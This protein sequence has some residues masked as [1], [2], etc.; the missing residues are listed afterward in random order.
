[1]D[2]F[3]SGSNTIEECYLLQKQIYAMIETPKFPIRKWCSN[4]LTILENIGIVHTDPLFTLAIDADNV[5]KLLGLSWKPAADHFTFYV[6]A[7]LGRSRVIK[8]ML[9]SDLN[10]VFDAMGFLVPVLVRGKIFV[11]QTWQMKL[12]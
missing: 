7:N 1:M 9:L 8:R 3:M 10:R 4:S 6:E 11:H 5:I 12:E 2:D